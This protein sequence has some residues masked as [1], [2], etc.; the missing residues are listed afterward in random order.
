MDQAMG[1]MQAQ[2]EE[3]RRR[4]EEERARVGLLEKEL[5]EVRT[6]LASLEQTQ[7]QGNKGNEGAPNGT[8]EGTTAEETKEDGAS[9]KKRQRTE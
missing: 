8:G 4:W 6:R 2:V 9:A 3:S 7:A 5:G 1:D